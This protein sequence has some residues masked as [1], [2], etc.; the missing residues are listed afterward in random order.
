MIIRNATQHDISSLLTLYNYEIKHSTAVYRYDPYTY[1]EMEDYCN[2][3]W[4]NKW[5]LLVADL[6]DEVVGFATYGAFR[7][8]PAYQFTVEHSVYVDVD[9]RKQGIARKL[10][11]E[12]IRI[13]KQ[14]NKRSMIGGIDADNKVS[15]AFHRSIGFEEVAHFRQVGYKFDR[16]LDLKFLQKILNT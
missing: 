8:R 5:P 11:H 14:N 16:W 13:G 9:H 4:K 7:T 12:L 15:I 6:N 3:K 10:M 2:E 1:E